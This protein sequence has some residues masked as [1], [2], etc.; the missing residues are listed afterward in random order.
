LI[1]VAW[2]VLFALLKS[3]RL[4]E[5]FAHPLSLSRYVLAQDQ[6]QQKLIPQ[7]L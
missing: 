4:E 5:I 2:D 1:D 7:P 3:L 6:R